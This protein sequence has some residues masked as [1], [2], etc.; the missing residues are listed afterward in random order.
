M[1]QQNLHESA[2]RLFL[3]SAVGFTP[4]LI[5]ILAQ[6]L[7]PAYI[8]INLVTHLYHLAILIFFFFKHLVF[9]EGMWYE[10]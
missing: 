5:M 1:F 9:R 7:P 6:P 4:T 8:N 2:I 3:S 10:S